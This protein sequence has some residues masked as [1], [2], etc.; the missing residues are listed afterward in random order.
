MNF[1]LLLD[2]TDEKRALKR[3]SEY[4]KQ[5]Y[6]RW[7]SYTADIETQTSKWTSVR[8]TVTLSRV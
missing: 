7:V 5:T 3:A 1:S 2:T 8:C 4:I 6:P